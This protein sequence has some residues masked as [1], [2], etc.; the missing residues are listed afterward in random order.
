MKLSRRTFLIL[1]LHSQI[2]GYYACCFLRDTHI[3][4]LIRLL[5]SCCS[6]DRQVLRQDCNT[7]AVQ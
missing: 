6:L 7:D 4:F 1:L 5:F 3:L 2:L